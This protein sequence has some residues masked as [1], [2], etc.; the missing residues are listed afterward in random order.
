MLSQWW[1]DAVVYQVYPRSFA[2]GSGDG[3]GDFAG[4]LARLPYLA[5]LGVEAVWFSPFYPSPLADGGYDVADYCDVDPRFGTLADFDA[6]V[7]AAAE[8]GIRVIVDIVPNHCSS[9]HPAF[10]AALE[11]GPGSPERDLFMFRDEPNNWQSIFGGPA[12]TQVADGQW[13]LHLFDS[14]QPDWNWRNPAVPAMFEKVIRFWLDRGVAGLRVDVAHGLFKDPGLPDVPDPAP[15]DRP[16]PWFHRPELIGHYAS[17]RA[18]L[19]SYSPDVFP[20]ERTAVGEFWGTEITHLE[21]YFRPGGMPQAFNFF[22]FQTAWDAAALKH[23]ITTSIGLAAESDVVAPWVISN[24]D[25][26]R[27]VTRYGGGPLA[28]RDLDVDVALGTRRARAAALLLLALPGSAY[29]YQGEEL[30]LPEV[31][32]IPDA[33][34][35]DPVFHRTAGARLGRDG[36]RV[37]IPWSGTSKPYGFTEAESTWLPQPANWAPLTVEAQQADPGSTLNL[38]KRAIAARPRGG[39]FAWLD[40]GDD[41]IA[42]TRGDGFTCMVNLSAETLPIEGE[43]VLASGP[44]E[45]GLPQDTAVWLR[46]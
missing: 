20:G 32:D 15:S 21:P 31:I 28:T 26:V 19:D 24:H 36:C 35:D 42:F 13:Y 14:S 45:G 40:R 10:Q 37:P 9:A 46:S 12:W 8:H 44:L 22:L 27:P 6:F 33:F 23:T 5:D 41:V 18:I 17:W 16:S 3:T 25:V 30:G 11:A 39:G 4:A 34:R 1:R 43:V 2:D 7:A 38:Y 29:V